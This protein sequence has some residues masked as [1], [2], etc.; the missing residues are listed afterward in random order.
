MTPV[1]GARLA[2]EGT[3]NLRDIGGY[4]TVDG[5][6]VRRGRLYRSDHL[7][8]VTDEGFAVLADLGLRTVLDLRL[9]SERD[10]QPSRLPSGIDVRNVNP[11]GAAG[12]AQHE[13]MEQIRSGQ[14]T[15]LSED[16][17]ATMYRTMLA[18]AGEMFAAV[19]LVAGR[20]DELPALFHCT[21][22]KDRT[23]LAAAVLLRLLGVADDVILAEFALTNEYRTPARIAQMAPEFAKMG[24]D[25]TNF[26]ALFGA[27]ESAMRSAL[28]WLDERGGVETYLTDGC[29]LSRDDLAAARNQMLLPAP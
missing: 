28:T 10:R 26:L 22:G 7:N 24:L 6:Q 25:I 17:I 11:L 9:Q 1:P 5:H 13:M 2:V 4:E 12:A 27:P 23:G 16:D 18:D 21:A 29:A 20:P 15:S 3:L 14:L 19:V 8:D